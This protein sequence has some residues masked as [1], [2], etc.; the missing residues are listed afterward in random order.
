[1]RKLR[2]L[3]RLI[4]KSRGVKGIDDCHCFTDRGVENVYSFVCAAFL[5]HYLKSVSDQDTEISA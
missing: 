3:N 4:Q 1:M 2:L 5:N